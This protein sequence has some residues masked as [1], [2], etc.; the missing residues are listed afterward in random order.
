VTQGQEFRIAVGEVAQAAAI[1]ESVVAV[2]TWGLA[3]VEQRIARI[4][5]PNGVDRMLGLIDKLLPLRVDDPELRATVTA[6]VRD[7]RVAYNRR[8]AVLH[9]VWIGPGDASPHG[10][11]NLKPLGG[12]AV[13]LTASEALELAAELTALSR[14]D[15]LNFVG[16]LVETVPGP[17]SAGSSDQRPDLT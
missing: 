11:A 12:K 5:L 3:G 6:W 15:R 17:W 4:V 1:L 10:K 13:Y 9:S 7:V 16:E 8:S 2:V 14:G